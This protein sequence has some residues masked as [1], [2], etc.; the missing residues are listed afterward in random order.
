MARRATLIDGVRADADHSLVLDA[1]NALINDRQPAV[2]TRGATSVDAL[3]RMGYDA[4]ALGLT[5]VTQLSLDELRA[6]LAEARFPMV[7]ANVYPGGQRRPAGHA[8]R[9]VA[10]G[11]ASG[12]AFWG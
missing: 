2:R 8:V 5:D 10:R 6:R 9:G 4:V 12:G 7:S 3:N 1:G 11:W